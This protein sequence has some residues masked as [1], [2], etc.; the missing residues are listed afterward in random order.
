MF[1]IVRGIR[2]RSAPSAN[3]IFWTRNTVTVGEKGSQSINLASERLH[4]GIHTEAGDFVHHTCWGQYTNQNATEG[5]LKKTLK[6]QSPKKRRQPRSEESKPKYLFCEKEEE[7]EYIIMRAFQ[8]FALTVRSQ[9]C[10]RAKS[11]QEKKIMFR[12]A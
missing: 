11:R 5:K 4:D 8:T 7:D 3:K 1:L 12:E 10:F 2:K 6:L 9:R